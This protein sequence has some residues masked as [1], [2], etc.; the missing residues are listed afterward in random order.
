MM[1]MLGYMSVKQYADMHGVAKVTVQKWI[2][3]GKMPGAAKLGNIWIIPSTLPKPDDM[4]F[5]S[6]GKYK[7]WRKKYGKKPQE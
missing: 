7:D 2:E 6:H 3:A 4:R 5:R 1:P